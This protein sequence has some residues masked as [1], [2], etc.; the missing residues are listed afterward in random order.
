M[1][2]PLGSGG[3]HLALGARGLAVCCWIHEEGKGSRRS[4][5]VAVIYIDYACASF[6]LHS[7]ASNLPASRRV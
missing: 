7:S 3:S 1:K 4:Q 2:D 6:R 5:V